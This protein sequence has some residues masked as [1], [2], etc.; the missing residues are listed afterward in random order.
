MSLMM[1]PTM[2]DPHNY[3]KGNRASGLGMDEEVI[4][5]QIEV[6]LM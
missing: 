5:L 1:I 2:T 4:A 3:Q 6:G